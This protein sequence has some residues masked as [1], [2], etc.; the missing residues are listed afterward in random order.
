MGETVG[1]TIIDGEGVVEA[2]Q[3]EGGNAWATYELDEAVESGA[4]ELEEVE[5]GGFFSELGLGVWDDGLGAVGEAVLSDNG[6]AILQ[7]VVQT[8]WTVGAKIVVLHEGQL[9]RRELPD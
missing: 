1:R 2:V 4:A 7:A 6:T 3:V 5:L 8:D 9:V